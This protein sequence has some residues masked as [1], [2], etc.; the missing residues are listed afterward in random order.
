LEEQ[1][2]GGVTDMK[3]IC[4]DCQADC[5]KTLSEV[6]AELLLKDHKEFNCKESGKMEWICPVCK[7]VFYANGP[8]LHCPECQ[9]RQRK[10]EEAYWANKRAAQRSIADEIVNQILEAKND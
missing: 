8:M 7:H 4:P 6:V 2:A 5:G 10:L 1:A 3:V 9:S